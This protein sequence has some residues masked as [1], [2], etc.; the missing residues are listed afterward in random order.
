MLLE[1][2]YYLRPELALN[3]RWV[4]LLRRRCIRKCIKGIGVEPRCQF[5]DVDQQLSSRSSFI[6]HITEYYNN[7]L[8]GEPTNASII[9]AS[10]TVHVL[11]CNYYYYYYTNGCVDF[12]EAFCTCMKQLESHYS[13]IFVTKFIPAGTK[14]IIIIDQLCCDSLKE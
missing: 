4:G 5:I 8:Q 11:D 7:Q 10:Y 14:K 1:I 9:T 6:R 13:I 12:L 3:S 2:H